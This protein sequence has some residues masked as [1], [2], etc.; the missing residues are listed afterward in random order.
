MKK[1]LILSILL[2]LSAATANAR[3]ADERIALGGVYV[4]Q[5]VSEVDAIYGKPADISRS[6]ANVAVM[7]YNYRNNGTNFHISFLNNIVT[8]VNVEGNNGIAT[9]DGIK[10]G[11]PKEEVLKILGS[12][13]GYEKGAQ[14]PDHA[15]LWY[16]RAS[17]NFGNLF[18]E[19]RY[20][21]VFMIAIR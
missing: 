2:L 20:G 4:G 15:F 12:P 5:S 14:T 13:D 19:V 10:V 8:D 6:K 7:Y 17:G 9:P 1:I 21:K 3:I 16:N 18:F 11:T